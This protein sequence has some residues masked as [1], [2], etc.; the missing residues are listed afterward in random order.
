MFNFFKKKPKKEAKAEQPAQPRKKK[1]EKEL[2]T[3]RGEPYVSILGMDVDYENLASGSI[4]LD[5]NE[6]FVSNLIR[7]GYQGKS[8]ADIVDLWFQNV[9]RNIVMETYE[10]E[11]AIVNS[12]GRG[13]Q[14]R[15]LGNGRTEVS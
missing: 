2:A 7:A 3:E 10:Q 8:D 13:P 15:D 11:E 12:N 4:E 6:K 1:T 14:T 9:C 5:W